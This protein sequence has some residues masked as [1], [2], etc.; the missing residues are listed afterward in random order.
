MFET[1]KEAEL[2]AP[3]LILD[4][5]NQA[6]DYIFRRSHSCWFHVVAQRINKNSAYISRIFYFDNLEHLQAL[7]LDYSVKIA[8]LSLVSP[9]HI[10][11]TDNWNMDL[12]E[13]IIVGFEP[14]TE[15]EQTALIFHLK[16]GNKYID[17][18]LDTHVEDLTNLKIA[19][20]I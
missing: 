9:G 2:E 7:K 17:S 12:L 11:G 19:F 16:N 6:W 18:A 1:Y 15:H 10:N 20:E 4:T 3:K 8:E 13:K 14:N 5:R